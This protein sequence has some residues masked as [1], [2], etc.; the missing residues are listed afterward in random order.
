M[1]SY[2]WRKAIFL[3]LFFLPVAQSFLFHEIQRAQLVLPH[4][5]TREA[6]LRSNS[7]DEVPKSRV[8]KM[9]L[10]GECLERRTYV[11]EARLKSPLGI[12]LAEEP[13]TKPNSGDDGTQLQLTQRNFVVV[14]DVVPGTSAYD[15]GVRPGDRIVATGASWG[16]RMWESSTVEGVTSSVGSK[17]RM[18][19]EVNLRIERPFDGSE[20]VS[21]RSIVT[22]TF[23]VDLRKPL[24]ITL[25]ERR[26]PP[27][28]GG[29]DDS[30]LPRKVAVFVKDLDPS[31][32]AA[33]SG[34]I[35][36]GKK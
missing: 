3:A 22:E 8:D 11:Y 35:R 31:G 26:F 15:T 12:K 18:F 29:D 17:L 33:A 32:T 20:E 9:R 13:V 1:N 27:L 30:Q 16:G 34:K 4:P 6:V 23:M 28:Q 19:G 24:G 14:C 7:F 25:E 2:V 5:E 21:W 36:V 10:V